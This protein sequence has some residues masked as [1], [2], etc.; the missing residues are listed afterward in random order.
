MKVPFG[1]VNL[2]GSGAVDEKTS[3]VLEA[4]VS[5]Y[6]D[7][8]V[9]LTSAILPAAD[10]KANDIVRIFSDEAGIYSVGISNAN[11]GLLEKADSNLAFLEVIDEDEEIDELFLLVMDRLHNDEVIGFIKGCEN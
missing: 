1:V 5:A 4:I 10:G 8:K 9:E 11:Y 2:L 6:P 3:N 7:D